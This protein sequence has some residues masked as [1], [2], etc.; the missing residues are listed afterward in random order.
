LLYREEEI[1]KL[2][3]NI[4]STKLNEVELEM[5]MYVDEC[6]RLRHLLEEVIKSKD[7]LSDPEELANIE[8]HFQ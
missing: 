7:P 4:K 1:A 3:K 6:T 5:K 8:E 2:K